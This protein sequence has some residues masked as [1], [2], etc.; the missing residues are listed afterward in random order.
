MTAKV[1]AALPPPRR[2]QRFR[3]HSAAA[4]LPPPLPLPLR[5]R[6]CFCCHSATEALFPLPPSCRQCA[7]FA[8]PQPPRWRR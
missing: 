3:W 5:R 1:A 8:E 7:A 6:C 4:T 2:R